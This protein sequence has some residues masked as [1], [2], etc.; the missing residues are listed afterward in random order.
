ML[1][2]VM[3]PFQNV[4][5]SGKGRGEINNNYLENWKSFVAIILSL[6]RLLKIYAVF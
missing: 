6:E 5:S 4:C 2:E 1:S 3:K